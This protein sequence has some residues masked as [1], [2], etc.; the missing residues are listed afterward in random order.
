MKTIQLLL[1]SVLGFVLSSCIMM[2]PD[3]EPRIHKDHVIENRDVPINFSSISA[4]NGFNVY[5]IH[6]P[7]PQI[8]VQAEAK[9]LPYIETSVRNGTLILI[10]NGHVR[11]TVPINVYV[12]YTD[13][14]YIEASTSAKIFIDSPLINNTTTIKA[15]TGS[16]IHIP[17]IDSEYIIID[18]TSKVNI[19]GRVKHLNIKS[20][21]AIIDARYLAAQQCDAQL[22]LRSELTVNVIRE[23]NAM[24]SKDSKL[25]YSGH[26]RIVNIDY[27]RDRG[28]S[29]DTRTNDRPNDGVR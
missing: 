29:T 17:Q 15:G 4:N 16:I 21:G 6:G 28:R 25:E 27:E 11:S 9:V 18:S 20:N 5:M 10:V 2:P 3:N 22:K 1:L 8:Q 7:Q 13:L 24:V 23:I 26:P 19:A 14:N 12:T